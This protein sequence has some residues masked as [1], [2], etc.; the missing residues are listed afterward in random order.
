MDIFCDMHR[1]V[2]ILVTKIYPYHPSEYMSYSCKN[3]N[4]TTT[5]TPP[6]IVSLDSRSN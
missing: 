3:V 6:K 5:K 2:E 4:N 1:K